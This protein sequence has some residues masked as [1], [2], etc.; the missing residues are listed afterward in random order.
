MADGGNQ[1]CSGE[2]WQVTYAEEILSV[3]NGKATIG[4]AMQA[5]AGSWGSLDNFEFYL[6]Q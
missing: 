2:K 4:V 3:K 6:Q 5:K 1:G